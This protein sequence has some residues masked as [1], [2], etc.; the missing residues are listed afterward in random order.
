MAKSKK[1]I[2]RG[3]IENFATKLS[4]ERA[5]NVSYLLSDYV[6]D[7]ALEISQ[8][9]P[10]IQFQNIELK[11]CGDLLTNSL[12]QM[13]ELDYY[14][15]IRS[16][17]LELNSIRPM[18][19]KLKNFW[20]KVKLAWKNRNK[21]K[22]KRALK[23]QRKLEL[24]NRTIIT[25][26]QLS[27]K[28]EKPYDLNDFKLDVLN[29]LAER[30][31]DMSILYSY[32]NK[33]RIIGR[34]EFGYRINIYPAFKHDSFLK[35]FNP[36]TGKFEEIEID[37][38]KNKLE[39]KS[40]EIAELNAGGFNDDDILYKM[41]R[42]FKSLYYNLEHSYSYRFVESMIYACPNSLFKLEENEHYVYNTFLKILNYLVNSPLNKYKSIY[43]EEKT[44]FEYDGVTILALKS[45]L[46]DVQEYL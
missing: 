40:E 28:K 26:K 25:E 4:N 38:A 1:I 20:N 7:I 2:D 41:I 6:D 37:S 3:M 21:K 22:S 39:K 11:T 32:P 33:I 17:Q 19:N 24:K 15:T 31:T 27:E 8:M 5:R 10:L 46:K 12:I 29:G 42:I 13:S 44:I 36:S 18:E 23:R 16:A 34:D 45:F 43:N 9:N 35:V 14:L 30:L